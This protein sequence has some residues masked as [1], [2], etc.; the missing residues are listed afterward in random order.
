MISPQVQEIAQAM[1]LR[2]PQVDSLESLEQLIELMPIKKGI[3]LES[4]AAQL[5]NRFEEF[6]DFERSFPNICFALATGVGKTRLMGA[7]IAF[8]SMAKGIRNFV[9]LS[10]NTTITEKLV[11]E[12]SDLNDPKYVFKGLPEFANRYPRIITAEEIE[13]GTPLRQFNDNEFNP[14]EI[15]INI[16]NIAFIHTSDRKIRRPNE[17][18]EDG[19]SYFDF[20]KSKTDL[21]LFMDEAHRYRATAAL[22]TINDLNPVL[23]IEL[24]ATP[25]IQDGNK[26]I[27]FRN[28]LY[29]FTLRNAL[30]H[31]FV[32]RLGICCR[33]ASNILEQ[34]EENAEKLKIEDGLVIHEYLTELLKS[35][36][37]NNPQ[38]KL[39]K[40]FV[41]IITRDTEHAD[42]I[43]NV[44]ECSWAGKYAGKIITVH[45]AKTEE[46]KEK[47]WEQLRAVE[48]PEN[49]I[50]IVI[51]VNMLRE[52]W[53]VNNLYTI[54][55]LRT[56]DSRTLVEQSLG[57]GARLPFGERTGIEE[58][59]RLHIVFHQKFDQ[60]VREVQDEFLEIEHIDLTKHI[61][62]KE[63]IQHFSVI[64]IANKLTIPRTKPE[65]IHQGKHQSFDLDL[66]LLEKF[67]HL[68]DEEINIIVRDPQSETDTYVKGYISASLE[69][70]SPENRLAYNL[71]EYYDDIAETEENE[72]LV[73]LLTQQAILFL[74]E[75]SS[76]EYFKKMID[77]QHLAI[78]EEIHRQMALHYTP[79]EVQIQ[80]LET[81]VCFE[82]IHFCLSN[83]DFPVHYSSSIPQDCP[84]TSILWKG[85]QK[86]IY[87]MNKFDSIPEL[88]FAGILERDSSVLEWVKPPRRM[89]ILSGYEPDF[90][91]ET[92]DYRYLCEIKKASECG[93]DDVIQK[94][95]IALEW[96]VAVNEQSTKPWSYL[97]I[98]HDKV[99]SHTSFNNYL[100]FKRENPVLGAMT[101]Q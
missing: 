28:V 8:L 74:Q 94:A 35:Y 77:S 87:K 18:V 42:R 53:D 99:L 85:F 1:S 61:L 86:S 76:D 52:G 11:R 44:I 26:T 100:Q 101:V 33:D 39:V 70:N 46:E 3:D 36:A 34:S 60:V 80:P 15:T 78:S 68:R 16:F 25:Q 23:G 48:S 72:K 13:G 55:P 27:P 75:K 59:D 22:T 65:Q 58:I 91:V 12:F 21:V 40:P 66:A 71:F 50:E 41:L 51:H 14:E 57:R 24:T 43:K 6:S 54:I 88:L 92:E 32:K 31:G 63:E 82:P 64:P 47:V 98:P 38:R 90:F 17:M 19:K 9:I 7:I 96:C 10:P 67:L 62:K 30:E 95:E 4:L 93:S 56:A 83:G 29:R 73:T 89:A 81:A 45:S 20:L 2:K 97:L 49:A 79:S 69:N 84:F 5:K 37:K